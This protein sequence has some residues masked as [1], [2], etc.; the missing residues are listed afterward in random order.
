ML[1]VIQAHPRLRGDYAERLAQE[2]RHKG[3]S[4]PARG[5][6]Q[7]AQCDGMNYRLIPA[8]AGTTLIKAHKYAMFIADFL[9]S[10]L[11][12]EEHLMPHNNQV[13]PYAL[14]HD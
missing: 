12:S 10:P 1:L 11:T 13:K 2:N 8:C 14:E 7:P 3:S 9:I 5:L 6:Q 4:P